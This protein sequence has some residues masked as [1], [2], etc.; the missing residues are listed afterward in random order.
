MEAIE[1][2][3]N[4]LEKTPVNILLERFNEALMSLETVAKHLQG[5]VEGLKEITVNLYVQE[6]L[7]TTED[8]YVLTGKTLKNSL[9]LDVYNQLEVTEENGVVVKVM[10]K[11]Y[12]KDDWMTVMNFLNQY[13]FHWVRNGT[14]GFWSKA[15]ASGSHASTHGGICLSPHLPSRI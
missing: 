14:E 1:K 15:M 5:A 3:I 4:T 7:K 13:G 6:P 12:M 11:V 10:P 9:A 8:N 2:Y